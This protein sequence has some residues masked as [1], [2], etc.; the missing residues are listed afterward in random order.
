MIRI[1][2]LIT[3]IAVKLNLIEGEKNMD[4]KMDICWGCEHYNGNND[5]KGLTSGCRAFPNMDMPTGCAPGEPYIGAPHSHDK[6]YYDNGYDD[7][8]QLTFE[9]Q[10]NDYVYTP[11]KNLRDKAVVII[12]E[13]NEFADENGEYIYGKYKKKSEE[14]PKK[15]EKSIIKD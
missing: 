5:D 13:K 3:I 11:A 8:G 9:G 6:P 15:V 7:F 1:I 4:I 12:Q 14:Q 2:I 10:R